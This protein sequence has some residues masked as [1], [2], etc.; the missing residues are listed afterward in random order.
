MDQKKRFDEV[1]SFLVE[2][3]GDL[4]DLASESTRFFLSLDDKQFGIVQNGQLGLLGQQVPHRVMGI[5]EAGQEVAQ[6]TDTFDPIPLTD[7]VQHKEFYRRMSDK[8]RQEVYNFL[9]VLVRHI[10]G[11]DHVLDIATGVGHLSNYL[12]YTLPSNIFVTGVDINPAY[13]KAAERK[14]G[15]FHLRTRFVGRDAL[16]CIDDLLIGRHNGVISLHG[17]G[18]L[19]QRVMG[20]GGELVAA[21]PCCYHGL[22]P[23]D[24]FM[25]QHALQ[26][27]QGTGLPI[28]HNL[29][30]ISIL[31][32]GT[33]G[34]SAREGKNRK[35]RKELEDSGV[36]E[37]DTVLLV[38]AGYT[39]EAVRTADIEKLTRVIEGLRIRYSSFKKLF[40]QPVEALFSLD[41]AVFLNE[42]GYQSHVYG[43][44]PYSIS[45][46]NHLIVGRK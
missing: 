27:I 32:P 31:G 3:Y 35:L 22:D 17:C 8:K 37:T 14:A 34:R 42:S 15:E 25:S 10:R 30:E 1:L 12:A 39:N 36:G 46:R 43:Y 7:L 5:L 40:T 4:L 29:A 21:S 33:L 44:M 23:Q 16:Q 45:P 24:Y 28:N 2:Y 18:Y 19:S 13:I 41:K 9:K 6:F 11:I 26:R 20:V 38:Q